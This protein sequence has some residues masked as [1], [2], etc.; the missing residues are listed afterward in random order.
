[1]ALDTFSWC[2]Q[3]QGNG[4]SMTVDNNDREVVY[5]NG[6]RQVASSGYNTTRRSF[7][8]VYA[9]PDWLAVRNFMDKHRIKPFA[10]VT[11]EGDLGLFRVQSNSLASK[12]V[13]REVREITCTFVEQF[14]SAG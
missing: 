4:G 6:Y 5:G 12:V 11:P 8:V 7:A 2:T 14:T 9:G 13:S 10:W 3:V 1:M